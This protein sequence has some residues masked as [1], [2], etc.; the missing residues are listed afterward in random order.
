[1]EIEKIDWVDSHNLEGQGWHLKEAVESMKQH[2]CQSVGWVAK[3][4]KEVIVLVS[5][6]AGY[7][8]GGE[9]CI[10]KISIIKRKKLK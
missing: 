9:I 3:E 8:Y 6:M 2:H 4:D 10:P 5:S 7:E 1:M